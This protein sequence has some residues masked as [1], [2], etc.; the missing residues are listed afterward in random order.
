[1]ANLPDIGDRNQIFYFRTDTSL[2]GHMIKYPTE[3]E[4]YREYVNKSLNLNWMI[5]DL[6]YMVVDDQNRMSVVGIFLR[7]SGQGCAVYKLFTIFLADM[8]EGLVDFFPI[9]IA[10]RGGVEDVHLDGLVT[11]DKAG[12]THTYQ[13][14]L[15][16]ELVLRKESDGFPEDGFGGLGGH[17]NGG[18]PGYLFE[19]VV[20]EF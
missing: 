9:P 3:I 2:V 4:D 15:L 19:V 13:T 20:L 18:P 17:R 6:D 10:A 16:I 8:V 14:D 11:A 7:F 12:S 5:S 1:M